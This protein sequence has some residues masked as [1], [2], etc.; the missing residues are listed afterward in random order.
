MKRLSIILAALLLAFP[1]PA[2]FIGWSTK[3]V[4]SQV[5]PMSEQ[6]VRVQRD[7][8][9]GIADADGKE[10]VPC[11]YGTVTDFAAGYCLL[12]DR[13]RLLGVFSRE[14]NLRTF[15]DPLFVDAAYPY[16]SEGLLAVRDV[17]SSWTYM[18]PEGTYPIRMVFQS[19]AP[20]IQ[21]MAAV[22]EKSGDGSYLHIDKKGR[23]NRLGGDFT[24][25]FLV[26]ASSFTQVDGQNVALVVDGHNEAWFRDFSGR[27]VFGLGK[28]TGYDKA[29]RVM[30]MKKYRIQFSPDRRVKSRVSASDNSEK[31]FFE[32]RDRSY[33]PPSLTSLT[34]R[35]DK[36]KW[37][38][39][40]QGNLLL[41]P[42]FDALT[43]LSETRILALK[44]GLWGVLL[45][46]ENEAEP[47]CDIREERLLYAHPA[48]YHLTG[49][50]NMPKDIPLSEVKVLFRD[51]SGRQ[52]WIIPQGA[53]FNINLL[54]PPVP[55]ENKMAFY[56][57]MAIGSLVYA[58]WRIDMFAFYDYAFHVECP[59][60][61]KM[62][63]GNERAS[64]S[65]TVENRAASASN[66][67]DVYVNGNLV[68]KG[69]VFDPGE[70]K[71]FSCVLNVNLEDLDRV[72]REV[73]VSVVE[74]GIVD[75]EESYTQITVFFERNFD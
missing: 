8:K 43:A 33:T 11:K 13:E 37:E 32:E 41:P 15:S 27:K 24:D 3:P 67:C 49:V 23:V 4:Y 72:Q 57:Q 59:K 71:S 36:G 38:V 17:E 5:Q 61:Q 66:P 30:T 73:R 48:D 29:T 39:S 40:R 65:F 34:F 54:T 51:E 75:A 58:S 1:A 63:A 50:L 47:Y 69:V 7:G 62:M 2:Q 21:G 12:L 18:T 6:W 45:V 28:V 60:T 26:F 68:K 35:E 53:M 64:L 19:A 31:V 20:F 52:V 56:T 9:W 10:V 16:F 55:G 25:T 70:T 46:R 42:Q 74:E 44:D 14:G 22:Q